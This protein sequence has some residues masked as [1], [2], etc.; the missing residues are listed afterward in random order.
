[1]LKSTN[2]QKCIYG[3]VYTMG[4]LTT[5]REVNVIYFWNALEQ[6]ELKVV[7]SKQM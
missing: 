1:M 7:K 6:L 2:T 5:T 4:N 3:H